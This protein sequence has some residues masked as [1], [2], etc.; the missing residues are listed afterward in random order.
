MVSRIQSPLVNVICAFRKDSAGT[1]MG[2]PKQT[3]NLIKIQMIFALTYLKKVGLSGL[4][5]HLLPSD[6]F[7]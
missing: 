7:E 4:F 1:L 2:R 5:L 6:V 3:Q